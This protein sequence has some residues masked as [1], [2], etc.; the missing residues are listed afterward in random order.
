MT[1]TTEQDRAGFE[2]WY[3][4]RARKAVP[5]FAEW[6]EIEILEGCMR[7]DS[8][9]YRIDSA[10]IAWDAWQAARRAPAV[11]VPQGW[12]LVPDANNMTDEQ[13]EAI[14]NLVSCCGGGAH[15]VYEAALSAAPQPPEAAQSNSAEFGG[16]TPDSFE[17][18]GGL[19][20]EKSTSK[21]G[22]QGSVSNAT[23]A[24]PVQMPEPVADLHE[25]GKK[26][27]L[28]TL[29]F[30][31]VAIQLSA[32]GYKSLPLYTEQQVRDLLAAHGI[33]VAP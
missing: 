9:S 24:A 23:L 22:A 16:I 32:K 8:G 30:S 13:A 17:T 26:P 20:C 6:S 31:K 21:Q 15:E 27:S 11:P 19:V 18:E 25:C 4:A 5:A 33:E 7:P 14:C 1:H 3:I 12:K 28:R 10:R 29:E 2:A